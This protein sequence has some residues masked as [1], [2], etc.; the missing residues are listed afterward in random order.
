MNRD[1]LIAKI[2]ALK[3][4]TA[5]AGC[6]EAEAM[7]AAEKAAAL[8]AEHALSEEQ[9][10]VRDQFTDVKTTFKAPRS[11]I[12]AH[13]A[14]ATNCAI[15]F[16]SQGRRYRLVFVGVE[17]GPEIACYL[18]EVCDRAVD[19]AVADFKQSPL[20]RARRATSTRRRAVEDFT[21]AMVARLGHR[22]EELFAST[23]S[24]AKKAL[25]RDVRDEMF[26]DA[27]AVKVKSNTRAPRFW[28]ATAQ[29]L[30]AGDK[31]H[32]ARGVNDENRPMALIGGGK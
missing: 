14:F 27:E 17:P 23:V 19:R 22:V 20:Y 11:K 8:M 7:S 6:T 9:L 3:A 2:K 18:R 26:P 10:E 25:A 32:L 24:P 13:I 12:W 4:M 28:Q 30:M 5:A 15:T 29:G 16:Q 31:V 1:K 21:A